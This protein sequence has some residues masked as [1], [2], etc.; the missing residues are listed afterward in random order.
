MIRREQMVGSL[1]RRRLA[2]CVAAD[3]G[4]MVQKPFRSKIHAL[5]ALGPL[6]KRPADRRGALLSASDDGS[7]PAARTSRY[8]T[9]RRVVAFRLNCQRSAGPRPE[10][11]SKGVALGRSNLKWGDHRLKVLCIDNF[12]AQG[13]EAPDPV[14]AG[15]ALGPPWA[16][17]QFALH[18]QPLAAH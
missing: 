8:E 1:S 9:T 17:S 3:V 12:G 15:H 5:L 2:R 13:A 14:G 16:W 6:S 10:W 4:T 11:K 7:A 18:Q